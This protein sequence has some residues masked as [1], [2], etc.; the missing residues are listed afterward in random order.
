MC[1]ATLLTGIGILCDR[2]KD[3]K[4]YCLKKKDSSP[5]NFVFQHLQV[6]LQLD[7]IASHPQRSLSETKIRFS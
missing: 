4:F 1:L 7:R 3:F 6:K 5:A 2:D